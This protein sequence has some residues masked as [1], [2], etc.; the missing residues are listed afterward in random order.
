MKLSDV[1]FLL[2]PVDFISY[3]ISFFDACVVGEARLGIEILCIYFRLVFFFVV[4]RKDV[5]RLNIGCKA[6]RR[7]QIGP[8]GLRRGPPV[9]PPWPGMV[10]AE[11]QKRQP[12]PPDP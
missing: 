7:P 10:E 12:K 9:G 11:S 1:F 5:A 2:K 8:C 3:V 6:C 4:K